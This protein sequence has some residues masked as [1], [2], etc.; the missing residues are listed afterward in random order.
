M[1]DIMRL[2]KLEEMYKKVE[3]LESYNK[4]LTIMYDSIRGFRHDFNNFI[5]APRWVCRNK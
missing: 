3:N 4:T 2:S 1:K 5:Q